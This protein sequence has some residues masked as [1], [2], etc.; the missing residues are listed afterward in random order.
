MSNALYPAPSAK[1]VEQIS[2]LLVVAMILTVLH[3]H[4]LAAAIPGLLVYAITRHIEQRLLAQRHWP[5]RAKMLSIFIVILLV[6][7]LLAGIGLG[8]VA[9]LG[10][11]RDFGWLLLKT[12]ELLDALRA[13]LPDS[14]SALV[15]QN[16]GDLHDN[17]TS[18]LKQHGQQIST[19]GFNGVRATA[20]ALVGLVIGAMVAWS[21]SGLKR[22]EKPLT[23]ALTRRLQRLESAFETVVFAQVR[24]SALNTALT[25][26][27]LLILL[28]LF[29]QH[30]PFAKT[31]VLLTFLV[32]LL[33]VIGNL[34]SN[35]AIMAV[36]ATLSLELALASLVFLVLIHKLEYFVNARIIGGRIHAR[37]WELLIAMIAMEAVFGIAG[38]ISAPVLY[39]Y[40][41]SELA[42]AGLIAAI[43]QPRR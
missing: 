7:L 10:R 33:P 12:A 6:C 9:F 39:A 2:Y 41:K 25:A 24:I 28:P 15:P 3:W 18:L 32:G 1:L 13:A 23:A 20:L 16:P 34:I 11:H 4:L 27:Y 42:A 38:L 29:G 14:L 26:I 30:L 43:P 17:T 36:S 35:T 31:L 22:T 40:L 21:H 5:H 37:A 19:I 8:L